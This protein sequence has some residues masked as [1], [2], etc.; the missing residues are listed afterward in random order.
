ME[1]GGLPPLFK[2]MEETTKARAFFSHSKESKIKKLFAFIGIAGILVLGF[3]LKAEA[4][5]SVTVYNADG[6]F[7]CATDTIQWV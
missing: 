5:G 1:Y 7:N 3:G 4:V 2:A 6:S